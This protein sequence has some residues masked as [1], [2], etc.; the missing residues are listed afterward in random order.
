MACKYTVPAMSKGFLGEILA[1]LPNSGQ[2][3][4]LYN[5]KWYYDILINNIKHENI[6]MFGVGLHLVFIFIYVSGARVDK[7]VIFL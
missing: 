4:I 1:Q 5:I 2:Y 7:L 6:V 3:L